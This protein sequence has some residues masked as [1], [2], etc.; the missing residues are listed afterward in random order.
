MTSS[1]IYKTS[2]TGSRA[3][4][5]G[6]NNYQ[7][8]S[9]LEYACND[10]KAV[11]DIL[12]DCFGFPDI[13][14]SVLQDEDAKKADILSEF[15]RFT[16]DEVDRDERIVFFFAG[17]GHTKVGQRGEI[18][19]LVPVDGNPEDVNSLIRWDELAR[20]SELISAK[21]LLFIVDAGLNLSQPTLYATSKPG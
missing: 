14:V 7:S 19:F 18:G 10:A 21:H 20:N 2:Y 5:V 8:V 3:L 1:K 16:K 4:V 17:H 13:Q 9:P 12:K 15:V 6:I 11:A